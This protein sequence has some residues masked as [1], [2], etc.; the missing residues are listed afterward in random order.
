LVELLK[1]SD[2]GLGVLSADTVI[3]SA[4]LRDWTLLPDNT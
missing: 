1:S 3:I 4:R 2:P